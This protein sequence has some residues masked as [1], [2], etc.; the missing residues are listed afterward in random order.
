MTVFDRSTRHI[1]RL[2]RPPNRSRLVR[3]TKTRPYLAKEPERKPHRRS[4]WKQ[5]KP[6]TIQPRAQGDQRSGT[7]S[8]Y[9][10][11]RAGHSQSRAKRHP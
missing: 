11:S 7:G 10:K 9:A 4:P 5:I 3:L 8:E 6:L 1:R 2:L